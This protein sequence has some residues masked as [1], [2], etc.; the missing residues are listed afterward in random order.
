MRGFLRATKIRP[1]PKLVEGRLSVIEENASLFFE[2]DDHY[3]Q[4]LRLTLP[5]TR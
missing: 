3:T 5:E 1:R 2:S 4:G